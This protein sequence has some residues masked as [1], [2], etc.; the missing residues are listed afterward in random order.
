M[1]DGAR[2]V[3]VER[4]TLAT[5]ATGLLVGESLRISLVV[6]GEGLTMQLP[7]AEARQLAAVLVKL[8]DRHEAGEDAPAVNA[9][10]GWAHGAA[11]NA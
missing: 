7:P 10:A 5:P 11:G 3:A 2:K 1:T 4:V 8:A 6:E 9:S